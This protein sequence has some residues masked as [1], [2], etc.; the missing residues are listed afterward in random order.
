[1]HIV[2]VSMTRPSFS[3]DF[4]RI[5]ALKKGVV[6]T[7]NCNLLPSFYCILNYKRFTH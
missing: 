1:M 2:L 4:I 6:A 5:L 7:C 3:R